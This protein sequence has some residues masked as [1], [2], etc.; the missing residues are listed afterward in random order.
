MSKEMLQDIVLPKRKLSQVLP[1][2]SPR[3]AEGPEVRE[4]GP[5]PPTP[6]VP[7][8]GNRF[9]YALWGL[10]VLAVVVLGF[11]GSSFFSGVTVS[12]VPKQVDA[13]IDGTFTMS[14]EAAPGTL[15]Y[16][17][18]KI[19][20]Q[21]TKSVAAT[22]EEN[23]AVKASGT[24]VVYNDYSAASMRLIKNTRFETASGLV[25]RVDR[26]IVVPGK[27][28]VGGKS[29]PGQV[30]AVVYADA[31]G[32]KYNIG[33]SDFTVPGLKG[34][35]Q[36][37]KFYARSKTEMT[38]GFE[39][40]RLT[41]SPAALETT[42]A[43]IREELR[44]ALLA[45]AFSQKPNGFRLDESTVIVEFSDLPNEDQKDSVDV[46]V[47]GTLYGVLIDEQKLAAFVAEHAVA[48]YDGSAIRIAN[49][50]ALS[51][52]LNLGAEPVWESTQVSVDLNGN[53]RLVWSVDTDRLARD[54]AGKDKEAINTVLTGYPA[55][56]SAEAV[57][58][59]FWRRSFPEDPVK[60]SIKEV[61]P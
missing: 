15:Q 13:R 1:S 53:P 25:Y 35:P 49:P 4:R 20:N 54:L 56:A 24:I 3:R 34:S 16:D 58:R 36:Y 29:V 51:V 38:G 8:S 30:E 10:A 19:D 18:M 32:T 2:S 21:G 40:K 14:R 48:G 26:A 52:D 12:V 7:R 50:D 5:R 59:P 6:P 33:L 46:R 42:R 55:I 47:K 27:K 57:V 41:V 28:T 22:G 17:I 61:A 37:E 60:I 39:G 9:H 11:I 44:K 23:A 43:T 31:P 45:A